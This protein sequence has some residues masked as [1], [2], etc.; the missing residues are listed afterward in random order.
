[1]LHYSDRD[2][3]VTLPFCE[4]YGFAP[5][6]PKTVGVLALLGNIRKTR[7]LSVRT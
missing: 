2:M 3:A 6:P 7:T 1:M 5:E 4:Y